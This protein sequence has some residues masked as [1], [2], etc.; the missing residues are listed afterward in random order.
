MS[1]LTA[2][3]ES[4]I[5]PIGL[6]A[7]RVHGFSCAMPIGATA[8]SVMYIKFAGVQV[9]RRFIRLDFLAIFGVAYVMSIVKQLEG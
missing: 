4:P 5:R 8:N 2:L 3:V 6:S 1:P 9:K 7:T